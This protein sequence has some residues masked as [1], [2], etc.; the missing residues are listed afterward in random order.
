MRS[1]RAPRRAPVLMYASI[2]LVRWRNL[3]DEPHASERGRETRGMACAALLHGDACTLATREQLA[4]MTA[5]ERIA[6]DR[7]R[8]RRFAEQPGY[9]SSITNEDGTACRFQPHAV[10]FSAWQERGEARPAGCRL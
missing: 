7:R 1:M 10:A 4:R 8:G 5:A 6:G 2:L 3:T 9:L